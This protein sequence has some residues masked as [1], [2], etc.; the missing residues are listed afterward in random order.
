MKRTAL[1]FFLLLTALPLKAQNRQRRTIQLEWE[2]VPGATAY[3]IRLRKGPKNYTFKTKKPSWKGAI[4]PGL[5]EMSIRSYDERGVPGDWSRSIPLKVKLFA[6]RLIAP[7]GDV[8][9]KKEK[10]AEV[11]FQWTPVKGASAY[12]IFVNHKVYKASQPPLT[13]ELP[14]AKAYKWTLIPLQGEKLLG[15]KSTPLHFKLYGA[16]LEKPQL[17]APSTRVVQQITWP[18]V[19]Y[20]KTYQKTLYFKE[21]NQWKKVWEESSPQNAYSHDLSRP[22]GLYKLQVVAQAP[23]R[24]AS[25]VATLEFESLGG[26][27]NPEAIRQAQLKESIRRP[28]SFYAIASYFITAA[29]YQFTT[30]DPALG[31]SSFQNVIGKGRIGF[32]YAPPTHP[33]GA[34]AIIDLAGMFYNQEPLV[35]PSLELHGTWTRKF[36]KGY[37]R[38]SGGIFQKELPLLFQEQG[39]NLSS[40]PVARTDAVENSGFHFGAL[41]WQPLTQKLGYQLTARIYF[42]IDG[43]AFT[44]SDA[45]RRQGVSAELPPSFSL[46]LLGSYRLKKNV[47]GFMGYTFRHDAASFKQSVSETE[48]YRSDVTLD[49]HYLSFKLEYSF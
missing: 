6:A 36:Y 30:E 15:E 12:H 11:A 8:F 2:P 4:Q 26:L 20:A 27:T 23:L 18:P 10:R 48:T 31:S 34:F 40:P 3:E 37:L 33:W 49:G 38:Y 5:Y 22:G 14:V 41:Y 47:M 35:F 44:R 13:I 19:P 46:G 25:P 42:P 21:N 43:T 39:F 32:G 7:K 16:P 45:R 24:P 29:S 28:S 17:Q 1:W 9:T